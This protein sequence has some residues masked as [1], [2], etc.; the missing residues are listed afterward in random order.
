MRLTK[1]V[2]IDQVIEGYKKD[3]PKRWKSF[4]SS[5]NALRKQGKVGRKAGG[6]SVGAKFPTYPDE[7]RDISGEIIKIIPDF[8]TNDY[9]WN[10]FKKKYPVFFR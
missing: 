3:Y 5:M 9:K 7:D 4:E 2:K 10:R 6:F 8:I 1:W